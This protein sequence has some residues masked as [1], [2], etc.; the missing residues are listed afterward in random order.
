MLFPLSLHLQLLI[1]LCHLTHINLRGFS[2]SVLYYS[3]SSPQGLTSCPSDF[4]IPSPSP[5]LQRPPLLLPL[6]MLQLQ[7]SSPLL[8]MLPLWPC[9]QLTTLQP[10]PLQEALLPSFPS[11]YLLFSSQLYLRFQDIPAECL[12]DFCFILCIY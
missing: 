7:P 10:Y 6:L 4:S 8:L 12:L 11:W 1:P 3:S 9:F 5:P 2:A